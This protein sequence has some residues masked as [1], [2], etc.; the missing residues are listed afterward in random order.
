MQG[1]RAGCR[2]ASC[3]DQEAD[4]AHRQEAHARQPRHLAKL[5]L[6]QQVGREGG[7]QGGGGTERGCR[8]EKRRLAQAL[9]C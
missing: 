4:E 5:F 9:G 2:S 3:L 7:W 1:G 8:Q 6:R